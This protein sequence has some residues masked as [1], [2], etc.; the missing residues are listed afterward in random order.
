ME[1]PIGFWL[2]L[3]DRLIT[4]QFNA[5]MEE[6][7][8]TRRQWQLLNVLA[9]T[10]ATTTQL[11]EAFPDAVIE[12]ST[13]GAVAGETPPE[14]T[15][16]EDIAELTESRWISLDGGRYSLTDLGRSSVLKL[17]AIV[18][19][20]R[21][22]IAEGISPAEYQATVDVLRRMASNLGWDDTEQ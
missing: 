16:G 6:H 13:G 4:D 5:A 11:A 7:G 17:T 21:D 20:N 15:T 10:P 1:R 9:E 18:E 14:E 19:R 3:V 22:L 8:V 2:A 12:P